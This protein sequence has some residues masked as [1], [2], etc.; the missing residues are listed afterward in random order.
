[1]DFS[2]WRI[3]VNWDRLRN[4][5]GMKIFIFVVVISLWA[6]Y[7]FFVVFWLV[8]SLL[9]YDLSSHSLCHYMPVIALVNFSYIPSNAHSCSHHFLHFQNLIAVMDLCSSRLHDHLSPLLY[10]Y[11]YPVLV[12]MLLNRFYRVVEFLTW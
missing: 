2:V 8:F 5:Y 7:S 12:E 9:L 6:G 10:P 11:F 4:I 1:M 3:G